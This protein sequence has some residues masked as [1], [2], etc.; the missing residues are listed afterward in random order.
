MLSPTTA[1]GLLGHFPRDTYPPAIDQ[2]ATNLPVQFPTSLSLRAISAAGPGGG[3]RRAGRAA[4]R[5]RG[6]AGGGS[7]GEGG[8]NR[9][10]TGQ[11]R[12]ELETGTRAAAARRKT[13]EQAR[14]GQV[15]D[16]R[17]QV[18]SNV[19]RVDYLARG[20]GPTKKG[21]TT[22]AWSGAARAQRKQMDR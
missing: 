1:R 21:A 9:Y 4:T 16:H 22:R 12:G 6:T 13:A 7:A 5:A 3:V 10:G 2:H 11:L 20:A 17:Y 15:Q 18:S 8:S 19:E 14:G